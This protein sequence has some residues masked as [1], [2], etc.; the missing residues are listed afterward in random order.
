MYRHSFSPSPLLLAMLTAASSANVIAKDHN[1][2][3]MV[4]SATK[5]NVSLK[6][7]DNSVLIKTGEEL[8]KAGIH[9]VKDLEK[10]FPG[11]IIQTRGK[12]TNANTTIR[13]KRP[14]S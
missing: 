13:R 5:Q 6:R 10:V 2:D 8:E 1:P 14:V 4:I 7:I 11:L 3:V 9:A 12:R